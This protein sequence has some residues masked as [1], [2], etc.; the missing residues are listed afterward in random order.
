MVYQFSAR[1]LS[2]YDV[3][4]FQCPGCRLLQTEEPYWLDESYVQAYNDTDTGLVSRNLLNR[5]RLEPILNLLFSCKGSF[6]D[7]GGGYGLFARLMRDIGIN[8]FT[9]DRYC[10]NIFAC[11]FAPPADFTAT[12]LFS[13]EVFE[14][15]PDPAAFLKENFSKYSCKTI[16]FTTE[17]YSLTIPDI[18][19]RYYG[20]SHGQHITFYHPDSL[21]RLAESLGC[22]YTHLFSDIHLISERPLTFLERGILTNRALVLAYALLTRVI[23]WN[24]SLTQSDSI[25]TRT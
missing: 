14:H 3:A 10:P 21:R 6:L 23:R 17:T 8:F 20:L 5:V 11:Q 1:I 16:F 25:Q 2:K 19:W 18:K 24:K 13:L 7:V 12:A 22:I 15:L 4:F 9:I